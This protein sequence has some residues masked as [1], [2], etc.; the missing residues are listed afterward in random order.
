MFGLFQDNKIS[1]QKFTLFF[2]FKCLA[3][4]AFYL[5][6]KFQYG[7]IENFDAGIYF[8][9]SQVINSIAS[10]DFIEY[11]KILFGFQNDSAGSSLFNEYI[12]K[13]SNWDEG[14]SN[15][16]FFNDNRS[17][18]RL[19]SIIH[20]ISFHNYFV[21]A[22]FSCLLSYIGIV[23]IYRS[24]KHL[25]VSKELWVLAAF[26]IIPNLWLFTGALL[27]EPIVLFDIGMIFYLTDK[28]FHPN[29]IWLKKFLFLVFICFLIC[30]LKPQIVA[31]VFLMYAFYKLALQLKR[32]QRA[33]IYLGLTLVTIAIMNFTLLVFKNTSLIQYLNLKQS[34]FVALMKGGIF[35]KDKEKFVR[36][37]YDTSLI[38]EDT[39]KTN[40]NITIKK[41]V[42]FDYW[43]DAD[44]QVKRIC[45]ANTD[46]VN[47]YTRMYELVPAR[48]SFEVKPLSFDK[49]GLINAL[50]GIYFALFYP[51][52]F[53]SALNLVVSLE[54]IFLMFC[55][56]IAFAGL[57]RKKRKIDLVFFLS[58]ILFFAFL[59]GTITPNTGAIVRYRSLFIPF[60]VIA[61]IYTFNKP[62]ETREIRK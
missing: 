13:T 14:F 46:T 58:I 26:T 4:P 9:D 15:R 10:N 33:F 51:I 59:F 6:Y 40:S 24:H 25:F 17:V 27:K 41:N 28:L 23:F 5:V 31:P 22:L 3:V 36:L 56:V 20:F 1:K 62:Y 29:V 52:K 42:Q 50:K 53:N 55:L 34:E 7:G 35:L 39:S 2:L 44:Q 54:N 19:H 43:L 57:I 16:L 8:K 18:I 48:S 37:S 12:T 61:A 30:F 32:R 60:L 47:T 21:H 38:K 11:L 45:E 49:N